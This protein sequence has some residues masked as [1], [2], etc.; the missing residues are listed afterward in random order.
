[1]VERHE[2]GEGDEV[3]AGDLAEQPARLSRA[4]EISV[5]PEE[6]TRYGLVTWVE[7]MGDGPGVD[8]LELSQ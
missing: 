7:A 3:R 6:L 8:S 1:M 5:A 4:A 2:A